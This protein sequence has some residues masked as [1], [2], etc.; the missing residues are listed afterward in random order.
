MTYEC[1]VK[2]Q[3]DSLRASKHLK[4]LI[5]LLLDWSSHFRR[6]NFHH[7]KGSLV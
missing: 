3:N 5:K 6:F 7:S 2:E 4:F 1:V